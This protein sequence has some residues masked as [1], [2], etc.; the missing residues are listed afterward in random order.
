MH[1]ILLTSDTVQR[2]AN[3]LPKQYRK[4]EWI[5]FQVGRDNLNRNDTANKQNQNANFAQ[6]YL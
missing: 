2:R 1:A 4:N 3:N 5:D 6:A